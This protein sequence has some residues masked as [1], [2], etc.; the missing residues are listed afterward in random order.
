[1]NTNLVADISER[2]L[3]FQRIYNVR[4][5]KVYRAWTEPALLKQWFAP[6]PWTTAEAHLDVRVG[7]ANRVTLRSPEG[8]DY[9]YTGVYLEVVPNQRLVYTDAYTQAWIPSLEPLMTVHLTF[10]EQQGKTRY[11]VRVLHWS[12]EARKRHEEMGFHE[13]WGQCADQLAELLPKI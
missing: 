6:A 13:G 5:E 2:E 11:T 12:V 10:E 9:P 3:G 8:V 7:G 4:P 1:M